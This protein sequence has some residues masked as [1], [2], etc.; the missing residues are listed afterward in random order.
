MPLKILL[1]FFSD[2]PQ[3]SRITGCIVK[4]LEG[5]AWLWTPHTVVAQGTRHQMELRAGSHCSGLSLD[6]ISLCRAAWEETMHTQSPELLQWPVA[7]TQKPKYI[8]KFTRLKQENTKPNK[9]LSLPLNFLW[10]FFF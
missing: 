6:V 4:V 3:Y 1:F 7:L 9:T 2:L 10:L 5:Q 8:P